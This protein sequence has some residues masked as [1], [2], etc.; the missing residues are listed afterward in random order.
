MEVKMP[1]YKL[2]VTESMEY[3]HVL[4]V[5]ADDPD[6]AVSK[7]KFMAGDEPIEPNLVNT[8]E[9]TCDEPPERV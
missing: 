7:A 3:M 9:F 5:V 6:S 4:E 1:K 8:L 2:V